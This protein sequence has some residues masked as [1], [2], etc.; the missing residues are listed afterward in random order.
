LHLLCG[1]ERKML[2]D[3]TKIGISRKDKPLIA[4]AD[5]NKMPKILPIIGK[6]S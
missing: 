2:S 4:P 6:E 1:G 5:R 3:L